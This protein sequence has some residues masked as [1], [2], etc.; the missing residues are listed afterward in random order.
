MILL[1]LW[2]IALGA[3]IN[4]KHQVQ[5]ELW[6][7]ALTLIIFTVPAVSGGALQKT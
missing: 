5:W 6:H 1:D 3:I 7:S 2:N 4:I